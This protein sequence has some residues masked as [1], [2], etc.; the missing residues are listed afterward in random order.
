MGIAR[1]RQ[2]ARECA[3]LA[4]SLALLRRFNYLKQKGRRN[5]AAT[6]LPKWMKREGF[7]QSAVVLLS[8]VEGTSTL[9]NS[10]AARC[11]QIKMF[12]LD[13]LRDEARIKSANTSSAPRRLDTGRRR[14]R[15][16]ILSRVHVMALYGTKLGLWWDGRQRAKCVSGGNIDDA[17]NT[18][19][20]VA[21]LDGCEPFDLLDQVI[22]D[23]RALRALFARSD[24]RLE[25]LVRGQPGARRVRLST[26]RTRWSFGLPRKWG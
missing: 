15:P 14:G 8:C 3:E 11:A 19:R 9:R 1:R 12:L 10:P 7:S 21:K 18:L 16:P 6:A 24:E 26:A 20:R 22:S 2:L 13:R 23:A 17:C 4:L 25:P 5:S